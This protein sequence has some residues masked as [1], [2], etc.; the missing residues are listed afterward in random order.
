[1]HIDEFGVQFSDD[2]KTL[3]ECPLDFEGDYTIPKEVTSIA[4]DAFAGVLG[5][6]AVIFAHD[7][8]SIG[9]AAFYG[10]DNIEV[11]YIPQ[12]TRRLFTQKFKDADIDRKVTDC[13]R[14]M[15]P[16]DQLKTE[17][18]TI[19]AQVKAFYGYG[20]SGCA[21][22]SK[23]NTKIDV[24]PQAAQALR[25]MMFVAKREDAN[26][27]GLTDEI[28]VDAIHQGH[29]EL[30]AP[31]DALIQ[32]G[33]ELMVHYW[34]TEADNDCI[35]ETL[36]PSF[37]QDIEDGL[38]EPEISLEEFGLDREDDYYYEYKD[39]Y[40]AWV[41]KH[42]DKDVEFVADREG[43]DIG[44][45]LSGEDDDSISFLITEIE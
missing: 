14:E 34:L 40:L 45:I 35:D 28:I 18:I 6:R 43:V 12:G 4:D 17:M 15:L 36:E 7:N 3:I 23:S 20:C 29:K 9:R 2:R 11:I 16:S 41:L 37:F 33:R 44:S 24:A 25:D 38:Y 22:S 8:V 1:M 31:Y 32:E 42:I 39:D 13:I 30:Q 5:L 21:Y 27:M 19:K 10:C 26:F